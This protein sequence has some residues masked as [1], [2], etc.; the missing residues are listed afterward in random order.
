MPYDWKL[1]YRR[2]RRTPDPYRVMYFDMETLRSAALRNWDDPT[3][4]RDGTITGATISPT[5]VP[6]KSC[7]FDG[8]DYISIGAF[9]LSGTALT[10]AAWVRCALNATTVQ[11]FI[12]DNTQ[13][14]TVGYI[15]CYRDVASDYLIWRYADGAGARW[16]AALAFF[17][18]Y[19][20]TWVHIAVVCDYAAKTCRFYRNGALHTTVNMTG[21]PVFPSTSRTRYL[22]AYNST[23]TYPLTN[24]YM[25]EVQLWTRA[26]TDAEVLA[27]SRLLPALP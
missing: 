8:D 2:R 14:S 17:T 27:E 3:G 1:L 12:G 21:T 23:P 26:L 19:D 18:N 20:D 6:A 5:G 22:G 16:A 24:G 4:T 10:F 7:F 11:T 13:S 25:D 9:G 15:W